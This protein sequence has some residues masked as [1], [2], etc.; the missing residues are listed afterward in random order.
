M[1]AVFICEPITY[2]YKSAHISNIWICTYV[3]SNVQP[4]QIKCSLN[5]TVATEAVASEFLR[6]HQNTGLRS[7]IETI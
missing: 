6:T 7:I 3:N 4:A 5:V 2:L 1:A